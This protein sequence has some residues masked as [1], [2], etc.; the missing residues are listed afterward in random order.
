MCIPTVGSIDTMIVLLNQNLNQHKSH[1]RN[2]HTC[3]RTRLT[4]AFLF[5]LPDPRGSLDPAVVVGRTRGDWSTL[6]SL[7]GAVAASGEPAGLL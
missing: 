5:L 1:T 6:R 4:L 3:H 7:E 2:N